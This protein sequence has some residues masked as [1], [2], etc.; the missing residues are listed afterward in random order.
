MAKKDTIIEILNDAG[1]KEHGRD[2]YK[3]PEKGTLFLKKYECSE[4][5]DKLMDLGAKH[6]CH[7]IRQALKLN[8]EYEPFVFKPQA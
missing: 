3:H 2:S 4:L 5:V 8:D 7:K 6:Q 1:F